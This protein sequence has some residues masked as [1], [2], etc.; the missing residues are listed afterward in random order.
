[1][2]TEFLK[3]FNEATNSYG[4]NILLTRYWMT[5]VCLVLMLC[6]RMRCES[7]S[8]RVRDHESRRILD[9]ESF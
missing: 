3:E 5:S 6:Y 9:L 1:M 8:A 4:K 7:D 2:L